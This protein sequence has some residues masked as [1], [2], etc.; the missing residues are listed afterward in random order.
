MTRPSNR[1]VITAALTAG[2]ALAAVSRQAYLV[3]ALLAVAVVVFAIGWPRLLGLPSPRT[4]T[5][6]IAASGLSAI[7][8]VAWRE[9]FGILAPVVGFAV[10]AAFIAEMAR[11]DGRPRLVESVAGTVMG[12]VV[13]I[14][15]TG[16]VAV[17][18]SRPALALIVT[19]ATTLAAACAATAL[20]LTSTRVATYATLV[21]TAA[22]LGLGYLLADVGLL[23]GGIIGFAA[24]V[25]TAAAY[26]LF[27]RF[28]ATVRWLPALAAAGVPL[29]MAG[30]PTYLVGTLVF[31]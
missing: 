12:A 5:V 27:I 7:G 23:N 3:P 28:P 9:D 15:A 30:G 17:G 6:V 11:R 26:L 31:L 10:L 25:L 20:P 22:G 29:L 1:G 4:S 18:S 19:A 21:A 24:G 8:L 2:L 14:A 16:W 13:A